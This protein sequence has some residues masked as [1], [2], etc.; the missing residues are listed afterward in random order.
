MS[1]FVCSKCKTVENTALCGYWWRGK[2]KPL[3][4]ECDPEFGRWHGSFPKQK[5]NKK[6]WQKVKDSTIFVERKR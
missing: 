3:C 2:K 1:L 5:F 6:E 4:S